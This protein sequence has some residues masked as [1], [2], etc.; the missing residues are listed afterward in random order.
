MFKKLVKYSNIETLE[1][2]CKLEFNHIEDSL[3]DWDKA[4]TLKQAK[5]LTLGT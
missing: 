3:S 1:P 5:E 4:H 2:R